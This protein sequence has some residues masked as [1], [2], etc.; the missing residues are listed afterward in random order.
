MIVQQ[1]FDKLKLHPLSIRL[2]EVEMVE[3]ISDET[4]EEL[5]QNLSRV[6]FELINDKRG[7]IIEQVKAAIIS[8]VQ[9]KNA[10][11]DQNL[12]DY[13]VKLIHFEYSYLSTL[14]SEVEGITIEKYYILQKIERVKELLMYDELSLSE[15]AFKMNY[16]SV[17]HL[18]A[19]FKKV[20]GF[21]PSYFKQLKEKKRKPLD[22]LEKL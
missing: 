11:S 4:K 3:N 6:G 19:Q 15:I 13:L 2:G 8:L 16:S 9:E 10:A 5:K 22:E 7:R 14:F 20:T 12:S 18:S 21:T 17:A 1:E